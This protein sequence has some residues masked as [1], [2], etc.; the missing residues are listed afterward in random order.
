LSPFLLL[1]LWW[2]GLTAVGA[3]AG[4][5]VGAVATVGAA[6]LSLLA[7]N[8]DGWWRVVVIQPA[9]WTVPLAFATMVLVSRRGRPPASAEHLVLSLHVPDTAAPEW[10]HPA[11]RAAERMN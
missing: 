1:S 7:P 8:G 3:A 11:S 6:G 2:R 9:A 5:A 10:A 4:V